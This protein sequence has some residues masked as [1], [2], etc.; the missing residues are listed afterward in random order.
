MIEYR[1]IFGITISKLGKNCFSPSHSV[2]AK[3]FLKR[4][5]SFTTNRNKPIV[6]TTKVTN[7][8]VLAIS[9]FAASAAIPEPT[10]ATI[11]IVNGCRSHPKLTLS[12]SNHLTKDFLSKRISTTIKTIDKAIQNN[13]AGSITLWRF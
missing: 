6:A 5:I 8:A 4:E 9:V 13:N 3:C 12:T 1:V 11:P 7:A 10:T 2:D